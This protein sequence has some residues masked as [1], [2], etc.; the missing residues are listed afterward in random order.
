MK[1]LVADDHPI[2]RRGLRQI[3]A[4]D[5]DLTVAGEAKDGDEAL[6]LART[7]DWDV[8]VL[9]LSMPGRSGFELLALLRQEFPE[10]PV[11]ILSTYPEELHAARVLRTG[12]AGYVSK[13]SAPEEL[14]QAIRKVAGG[15]VYVSPAVA[16]VLARRLTSGSGQ[17]LHEL[18]S[19]R[20]Y[21]VMWLLTSGKHIA[22]IAKELG[23]RRS[24]VS[25]YRA[26]VL[27]KLGLHNN[28]ELVRYAVQHELVG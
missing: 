11:L 4:S 5:P 22:E 13:E 14:A 21:R 20:E 2:I 1:I 15:G 28:A 6:A 27:G 23:L 12:A 17:P 9:D 26:R 16:E 18:L 8:S 3:L 10:R 25:T 24:T 19:D 7:I